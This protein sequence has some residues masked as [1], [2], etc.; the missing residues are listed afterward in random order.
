LNVTSDAWAS[1]EKW[2]EHYEWKTKIEAAAMAAGKQQA[3][4]A[5][6]VKTPTA[7]AGQNLNS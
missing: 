1:Y 2:R 3:Q 7:S 5:G 4:P 6:K